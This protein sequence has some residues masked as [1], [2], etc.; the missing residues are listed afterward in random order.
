MLI[1]SPHN[2]TGTVLND[3]ELRAIAEIAVERD[4]IVVTD[5]VYEHIT[6]D[7]ATASPT[8]DVRRN[9]RA[10]ARRSPAV[11]RPSR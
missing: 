6:F 7:G 10:D 9:A 11:A 8:G 5:E 2:P 4:L 1:N 3:E